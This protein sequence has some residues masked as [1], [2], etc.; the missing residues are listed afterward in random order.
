MPVARLPAL[1]YASLAFVGEDT[2]AVF[3][4][5]HAATLAGGYSRPRVMR[6]RNTLRL[7]ARRRCVRV[8]VRSSRGL[9]VP[10]GK[11]RSNPRK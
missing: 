3:T 1:V 4:E 6:V 5:N 7:L 2:Y 9:A 8:A 11:A 10:A